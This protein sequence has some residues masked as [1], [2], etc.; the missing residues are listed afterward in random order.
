MLLCILFRDRVPSTTPP[1]LLQETV[2]APGCKNGEQVFPLA[3]HILIGNLSQV[4]LHKICILSTLY[5]YGGPADEFEL[6]PHTEARN[7]EK[8]ICPD[9]AEVWNRPML[10]Q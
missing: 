10:W 2:A 9:G 6:K 3:I 7:E 8:V 1:S 4:D 5:V